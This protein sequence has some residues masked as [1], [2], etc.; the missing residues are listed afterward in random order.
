MKGSRKIDAFT[1]T[2]VMITMAVSAVVVALSYMTYTMIG[3]YFQIVQDQNNRHNEWLSARLFMSR[4]ISSSDSV[5]GSEG[6]VMFYR[7]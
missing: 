4:D 3:N 2:E 7:N 1:L 6:S 5:L